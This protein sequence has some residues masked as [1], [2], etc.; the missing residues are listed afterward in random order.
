M[1]EYTSVITRKGQATVPI[2]IR[3][4]LGLQRGDRIAWIQTNGHVE[5]RPAQGVTD[6]TAGIIKP[7]LRGPAPSLEEIDEIVERA[8]GLDAL[9]IGDD[10]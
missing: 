3:K 5:V 9:D 4:A 2:D 6:R 7:Y 8:I 10:E 1:S